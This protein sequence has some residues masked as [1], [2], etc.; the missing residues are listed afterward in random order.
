VVAIQ[1]QQLAPENLYLLHI[2]KQVTP[3]EHAQLRAK[4]TRYL[5]WKSHAG[6]P[7]DTR[8]LNDDVLGQD[9]NRMRGLNKQVTCFK[10]NADQV[11]GQMEGGRG[12]GVG[13]WAASSRVHYRPLQL[14]AEASKHLSDVFGLRVVKA[15]T[16]HFKNPKFKETFYVVNVVPLPPMT[17][18]LVMLLLR[19][20]SA[21][22]GCFIKWYFCCRALVR[23]FFVVRHDR[24][25]CIP[26]KDQRHQ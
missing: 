10:L 7:I 4:M 14:F 17:M 25:Y 13:P 19:C 6:E 23:H 15:P 22:N 8:K 2:L 21:R 18:K 5:L 12:I 3:E 9:Y 26:R 20:C 11:G 24:V 1:V 16:K